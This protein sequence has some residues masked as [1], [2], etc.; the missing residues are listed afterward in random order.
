M[1]IISSWE[2]A[3]TGQSNEAVSTAMMNRDGLCIEVSPI[4]QADFSKAL[5]RELTD[6][7][8]LNSTFIKEAIDSSDQIL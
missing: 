2:W 1:T 5:Y 8:I 7:K 6:N 3:F 4:G